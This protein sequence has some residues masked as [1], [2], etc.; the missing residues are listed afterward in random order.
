VSNFPRSGSICILV[1]IALVYLGTCFTPVIFDDN[2]G[3][4]AGA[5]REM[6]ARGDWLVPMSNGFPRVQKPP[7]VY[8]T[9]LVSTGV[10]GE[11][12]FALRLPNALATA[13]WIV[14][15]Y[16]IARRVGGEKGGIMSAMILAS[17]LGVWI[18]NH[19]VQPEPF[20]ACFTSLALWCLV[21]TRVREEARSVAGVGFW[22]F[23]ALA[24]MS[25]GL[26][27][28][29]WP[30]G[31]A[32]LTAAIFPSSRP[33][34]RPVFRG[35]GLALFLLITGPWYVYMATHFRGFLAAH[36]L[37]EQVGA[38][39][40]T[41]FPPDT[42]QISVAQFY[43]Q[44][45][46]FWLPWTLLLPAAFYARRK[47]RIFSMAS[48]G[49][50]DPARTDIIRLLAVWFCVVMTTVIFSA[51]QD[52]YGMSCWGVVAMFCAAPWQDARED[53]WRRLLVFVPCMLWAVMGAAALLLVVGVSARGIDLRGEAAAPMQ[54]RDTFMDAITGI[55]PALWAHF[56]ALLK[57]FGMAALAAGAVASWLAW[58]RRYFAALSVWCASMVVPIGL[59]TAGFTMMSSYFSLAESA[60]LIN[61][62]LA[63]KP[64]AMVACEALPNTASSLLYYLNARV[65]WVN[66][67]FNNQYA[68]QVLGLGRDY[69]WD[70]AETAREW[71]SG[72]PLFLIVEESRL[73]Y[74]RRQF[75][76]ARVLQRCGTRVVLSNR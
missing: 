63:G 58:R 71:Q 68:Q 57:I 14:A 45:L 37:N 67:P 8:W 69:Y 53:R 26:H 31:T 62:E 76:S 4:Y 49:D 70:D 34:L 3:L 52:Y 64:D 54:D 1:F 44:H 20:L 13:G 33:W 66:A 59:A 39:F 65:H 30:L 15:T 43:G 72:R 42:H 60:R 24:T 75:P 25:K 41:R 2:E 17:M 46:L 18:F 7:L 12:E 51:R 36:F 40:G 50:P 48:G 73:D 6:H 23:A 55:S 27:G 32:L 56:L 47:E 29:L 28:V 16:L 10:L 74:W 11:N 22:F 61:R 9:M 38:T 5:V 21:E 35:R 19:L